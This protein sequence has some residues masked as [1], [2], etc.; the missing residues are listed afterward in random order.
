MDVKLDAGYYITAEDVM[1]Y[2]YKLTR[3]WLG[4]GKVRVSWEERK[5]FSVLILSG[6]DVKYSNLATITVADSLFGTYH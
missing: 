5:L 4:R 3:L 6:G 2:E 1:Q